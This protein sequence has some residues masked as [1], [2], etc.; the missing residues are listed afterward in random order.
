MHSYA[1]SETMFI[2]IRSISD[3][4][5]RLRVREV[6]GQLLKEMEVVKIRG[7]EQS[8]GNVIAFDVEPSLGMRII[9]MTRA[10]A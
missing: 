6:A 4:Y 2:R 9:P 5:I 8:T 7:A 1:F 10:K 3:A